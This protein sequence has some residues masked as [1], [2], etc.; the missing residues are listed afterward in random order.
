MNRTLTKKRAH[1]KSETLCIGVDMGLKHNVAVVLN[2]SGERLARFGFPNDRDGYDYF[3]RRMQVLQ[4]RRQASGVVV[5]MEPTNYFWKLLVTELRQRNIEYRLVNAYT[6]K[7]HR[8]GDQLDRSKDDDR[9]ALTIADLLRTGKFTETRLLQGHYSD[10][11]QYVVVYDRLR[12]DIRRQ[13]NLIRDVVGQLFPEL[14]GVFKDFTGQTILAML[15]H[16][17]AAAVVR[18]MLP[19]DFIAAVRADLQ[20]RRLM[21]TKLRRVHQ[22]AIISVGLQDGIQGLQLGLQ[23]HITTLQVLQSQLAE[24][25]TT[26]LDTF[27]TLPE[28]RYLMSVPGLGQISAAFILAEVGDPSHY[29]RASQ[30]IKLAGTQPVPNKSGQKRNSRTPMSR[31]GRPRL[32][33]TLF[34]AVMRLVQVD[35]TFA[36]HYQAFQQREDKPLTKMEALGAMM[37]RLLRILWALVRHQRIYDPH[38]HRTT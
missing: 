9:D 34:F 10:L 16:H 6:V 2:E 24:V 20:G 4:E 14:S 30:W 32:R 38:Y 15:R 18:Q 12:R 13:K 1:V 7:K 33:T 11:R 35:D 23:G 37:N 27:L 28:S 5:A 21:I 31:Q 26:L 8:E 19:E 17:A 25:Q 36:S 22:L 29:R 3:H